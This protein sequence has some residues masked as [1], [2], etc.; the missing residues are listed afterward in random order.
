MQA[1]E[2][3]DTVPELDPVDDV[4]PMKM[5]STE[6][7][8]PS[9]VLTVVGDDSYRSV[10]DMLQLVSRLLHSTDQENVTVVKPAGLATK[11]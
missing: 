9:I 7:T 11:A 2:H 6:L 1:L 4:Q 10:E 5:T 8:Q 3:L